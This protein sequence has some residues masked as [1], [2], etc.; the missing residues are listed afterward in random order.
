M[1]YHYYQNYGFRIVIKTVRGMRLLRNM[2]IH[3]SH[4]ATYSFHVV[5]IG[6]IE[7]YVNYLIT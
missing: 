2:G 7:T 5:K 6:T 3:V 4:I 1:L